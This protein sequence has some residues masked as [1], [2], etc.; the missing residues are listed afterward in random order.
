MKA[1]SVVAIFIGLGLTATLLVH[2]DVGQIAATLLTA[3][4]GVL[5]VV[6]FHLPQTLFSTL[7]WRPLIDA[8]PP[9]GLWFL[10]R[11][12]WIR[13]SANTLLPTAQIGGDV[14]RARLLAQGGTPLKDAVASTMADFSVELV[15]QI[16]F[17]LV[18][19]GLLL[20]GPHARHS[21]PLA[22]GAA[23][24][25]AALAAVFVAAQRLGLFTLVERVFA[26]GALGGKWPSLGALKGLNDAIFM[27]Y[28][29]PTRVGAAALQHLTSWFLG[30]LETYVALKV[31]G[32]DA[33]LREAV[34]IE[35]LGQAVRGLG[36]LIPGA[37]G[38]QEGGYMLICAMFGISPARAL[39]LSLIR[40]IRELALGVPGLLLW[41]WMEGQKLAGSTH[42][43]Q[44]SPP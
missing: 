1:S 29:Q 42:T 36:F 9:P 24:S 40:R 41:Q 35:S 30:A 25:L 33:D 8:D 38:V 13:E 3:G 19:V 22:I 11:A 34:I 4:W 2:N 44:S 15:T 6:A 39:A 14:L 37:L 43:A 7:A 32:L 20:D 26:K 31:L 10:Y 27:I 16:V 17:T 18:G 23:L 12:R 21:A 5:A 28:R